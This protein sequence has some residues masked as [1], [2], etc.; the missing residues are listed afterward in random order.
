MTELGSRKFPWQHTGRD[1]V[2]TTSERTVVSRAMI[3]AAMFVLFAAICIGAYRS[4]PPIY[5]A[6]GFIG[7]VVL[8]A[9]AHLSSMIEKYGRP[10]PR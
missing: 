10:S 1:R 8:V 4:A 2:M 5:L 9:T 3:Y 7:E 6:V